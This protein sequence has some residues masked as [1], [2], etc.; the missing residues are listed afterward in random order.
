MLSY[1]TFLFIT[2]IFFSLFSVQIYTFNATAITDNILRND[3]RPLS[4]KTIILVYT[5][6]N[7]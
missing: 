6:I 3:G 5:Y 4:S 7:S 1:Y 2:G